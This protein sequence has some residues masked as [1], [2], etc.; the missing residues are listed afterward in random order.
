MG[1]AKDLPNI[2]PTEGWTG[3]EIDTPF[4]VFIMG[5]SK[6]LAIS[7]TVAGGLRGGTLYA[8]NDYYPDRNISWIDLHVSTYAYIY[9]SHRSIF[10]SESDY[11]LFES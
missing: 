10:F 11:I 1:A 3:F 5:C 8:S 7:F 6:L 9:I 2:W 4:K